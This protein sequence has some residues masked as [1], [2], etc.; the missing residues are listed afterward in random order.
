MAKCKTQKTLRPEETTQGVTPYEPG[1]TPVTVL[2]VAEDARVRGAI[3]DALR[4][5]AVS[6]LVLTN[7]AHAETALGED[8]FDLAIVSDEFAGGQSSAS[9]VQRRIAA[10]PDQHFV[11]VS[12]RPTLEKAM[13]AFEIGVLDFIDT[14]C[15]EVG[16]ATDRLA[17][18]LHR[19]LARSYR[20]RQRERRVEKLQKA[21][22]KLNTAR[23][24]VTQQLDSLCNDMVTAYQEL[25]E[26]MNQVT[27]ASEFQAMIRPEL[28]IESCLRTV[29]EFLLNISGPTNAAVYLPSNGLDY[30]LGAYVN[31]DLPKDTLDV[32]L[33][34]LADVI[35]CRVE[36]ED[37]VL[38]YV[39]NEALNRFLGDDAAW[40]EDSHVVTFACRSEDECLAVVVLFR[41]QSNR[42]DS[43]LIPKLRT[44]AP[45]F[46]K[47]LAQIIHIHH[48]ASPNHEWH[49][50]DYEDDT[51][52]MAA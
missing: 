28:D 10:E 11:M 34:H 44:I 35:P 38:E 18:R 45:I 3:R 9:F 8:V 1:K 36:D 32:L 43:E 33:D 31:Y 13:A 46:G 20:D 4:S 2:V 27:L 50:F 23:R 6:C 26:Q 42:F 29:L 39:D 24:E 41:D 16:E 47:Q 48:R 30:S 17:G 19:S 15:E 21:C 40:I 52:G 12:E 49:G 25:A 51:G 22:K 14:A 7:L 37:A 5:E